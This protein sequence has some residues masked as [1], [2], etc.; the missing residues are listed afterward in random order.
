MQI[1]ERTNEALEK[2]RKDK[3]IGKSLEAEIELSVKKDS[4]DAKILEEFADK[5]P[6]IFI[7]SKVS[8]AE[9]DSDEVCVSAR[10]AGGEKCARCWRMVPH[11]DE[12]GLCPRCAEAL[13]HYK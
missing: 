5:L 9:G 11:I 4:Q 8:L 1:R 12:N 10:K 7:V 6:E 2:L 13:K 3:T